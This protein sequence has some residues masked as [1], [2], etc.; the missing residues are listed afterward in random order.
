VVKVMCDLL[1]FVKDKS[2]P[3]I[4]LVVRQRFMQ[5]CGSRKNK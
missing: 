2:A 5:C 1:I 3:F 4:V